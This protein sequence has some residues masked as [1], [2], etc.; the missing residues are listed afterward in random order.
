MVMIFSNTNLRKYFPKIFIRHPV[1]ICLLLLF[2]SVASIIAQHVQSII[3][4]RLEKHLFDDETFTQTE[5]ISY[6]DLYGGNMWGRKIYGSQPGYSPSDEPMF[7]IVSPVD[8]GDNETNVL[9]TIVKPDISDLPEAVFN[10]QLDTKMELVGNLG[11]TMEDK[12]SIVSFL[13]T[14]SDNSKQDQP[15]PAQPKD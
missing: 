10:T 8:N 7:V 15:P 13:N 11:L 2:F 14:L 5:A 1:Y 9:V 3:V 12:L 6:A 4:E